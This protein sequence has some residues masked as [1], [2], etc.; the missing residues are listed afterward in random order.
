MDGVL[1]TNIVVLFLCVSTL[2]YLIWQYSRI[3]ESTSELFD[4]LSVMEE[5]LKVVAVVLERLPEMVPQ[6]QIQQNPLAQIL[7]FFQARQQAENSLTEQR[8]RGDDGRFTDATEK[9]N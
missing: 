3:D 2:F 8:L 5:S 6:F 1:I 7:E 9:E 4:A